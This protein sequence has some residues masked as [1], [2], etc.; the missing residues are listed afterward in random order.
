M[1]GA[2]DWLRSKWP[3]AAAG[4]AIL[5]AVVGVAIWQLSTGSSTHHTTAEGEGGAASAASG[6]PTDPN[7]P[8]DLEKMIIA[9]PRSEAATENQLKR[10]IITNAESAEPTYK[11]EAS[12][13]YGSSYSHYVHYYCQGITV[14][15]QG[16]IATVE[17]TVDKNTGAVSVKPEV[18]REGGGRSETYEE[19]SE[20]G[21]GSEEAP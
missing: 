12:C 6:N 13:N 20:S 14:G 2:L 5:I 17:V 1:S 15:G 10:Q 8:R 19:G 21:G 18:S 9:D 4:A 16:G 7:E 11:Q 3:L